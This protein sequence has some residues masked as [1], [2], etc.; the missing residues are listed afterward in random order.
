MLESASAKS[1]A[2]SSMGEF[3]IDELFL[4]VER[5][6]AGRVLLAKQVHVHASHRDDALGLPSVW[7]MEQTLCRSPQHEQ[8]VGD[9]Q[10]IASQ[11]CER[12]EQRRANLE[13]LDHLVRGIE[14]DHAVGI[15]SLLP[16]RLERAA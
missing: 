9:R 4:I 16:L 7:N 1:A 15:P 2:R 14:E 5:F 3:S 13:I 12:L 8:G 11:S 10:F 6:L